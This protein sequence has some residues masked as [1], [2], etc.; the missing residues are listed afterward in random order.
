MTILTSIHGRKLGLGVRGNLIENRHNG[1]IMRREAFKTVTSAQLLAL[2]ATPVEL[3]AAP[4]AGFG[5]VIRRVRLHKPAGVA[6]AG[7][8]AGEDLVVKYTDAAGAQASGVVET[9]GF[10]DST[11]ATFRVV[12]GPG[13]TGA[14]AGDV[15]PVSAAALVL[16][17]LV[18]EII[19]GDSP[20]HVIVEYDT[21]RLAF[22]S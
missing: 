9:T 4:A 21:L 5:H 15:A 17:L 2:F 13:S 6:Y 11:S 8:L 16:H 18:G 14:T 3:V 12:G 22:T 1:D 20:L 19:T 10:L 7:I